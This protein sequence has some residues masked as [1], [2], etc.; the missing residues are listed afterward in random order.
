MCYRN[1]RNSSPDQNRVEEDIVQD[2]ERDLL[3]I[4]ILNLM[5]LLVQKRASR[6]VKDW[7]NQIFLMT[8]LFSD[9]D[10]NLLLKMKGDN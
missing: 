3:K 5:R 8:G 10:H 9:F 4:G 2:R 1:G 6:D 7:K